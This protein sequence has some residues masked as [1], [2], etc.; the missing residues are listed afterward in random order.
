MDASNRCRGKNKK[1]RDRPVGPRSD[2]S[3]CQSLVTR[4]ESDFGAYTYRVQ[5]GTT[6]STGYRYS[7]T[8]YGS[9]YRYSSV[10]RTGLRLN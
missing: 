6:S 7:S 1:T 8:K 4:R 2:R 3:S 10:Y 5:T 9:S